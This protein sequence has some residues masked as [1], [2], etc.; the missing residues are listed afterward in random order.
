MRNQFL[1]KFFISDIVNIIEDYLLPNYKDRYD[2]LVR[3]IGWVGPEYA[4]RRGV[5]E[6]IDIIPID[7]YEWLVNRI[8]RENGMRMKV[9]GG[10]VKAFY[11]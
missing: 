7:K 2:Y 9:E 8:R 6:Y 11:R 3:V 10:Y 4:T 1:K 5:D